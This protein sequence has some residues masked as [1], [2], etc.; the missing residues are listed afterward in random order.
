MVETSLNHQQS[1]SSNSN[2]DTQDTSLK[3]DLEKVN[4]KTQQT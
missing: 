1:S 4:E 2:E 3:D